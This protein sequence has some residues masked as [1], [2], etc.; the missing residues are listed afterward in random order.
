MHYG[1]MIILTLATALAIF[2]TVSYVLKQ[3]EK[4]HK[5]HH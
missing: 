4:Q 3:K 5:H 1:E 2:A